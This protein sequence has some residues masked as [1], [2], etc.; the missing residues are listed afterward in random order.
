MMLY[1][2]GFV[3]KMSHYCPACSLE[4][5]LAAFIFASGF[6]LSAGGHAPRVT[7]NN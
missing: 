4:Q 7:I 5:D 2:E 6:D 1:L 3:P